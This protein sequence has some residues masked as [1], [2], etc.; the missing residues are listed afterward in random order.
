MIK[1]NQSSSILIQRYLM[2][3]QSKSLSLKNQRV[4]RTF[5]RLKKLLSL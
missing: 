5:R 3:S 1:L 2:T 4:V